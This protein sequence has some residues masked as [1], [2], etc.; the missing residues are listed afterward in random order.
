MLEGWG[1]LLVFGQWLDSPSKLDFLVSLHENDTLP[2]PLASSNILWESVISKQ[3]V[4]NLHNHKRKPENP[5][6]YYCTFPS[7]R[8]GKILV[9]LYEPAAQPLHF[10]TVCRWLL[11]KIFYIK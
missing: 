4:S 3:Y 9:K 11:R 7:F 8:N 10:E 6:T 2:W 5:D 1:N